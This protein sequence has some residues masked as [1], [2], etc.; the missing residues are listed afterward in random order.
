MENWIN[1]NNENG[2]PDIM[3][4]LHIGD[5][6][7]VIYDERGE[8]L[9]GGY[10]TTLSS[11]SPPPDKANNKIFLLGISVSHPHNNDEEK[12]LWATRIKTFRIIHK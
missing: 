9:Y 5:F 3:K 1:N 2:T 8:R 7:E 6:V 4:I 11:N 12:L 10:I